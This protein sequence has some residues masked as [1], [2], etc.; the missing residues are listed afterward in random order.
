MCD[1]NITPQGVESKYLKQNSLLLLQTAIKGMLSEQAYVDL[2]LG[3]TMNEQIFAAA[4][5]VIHDIE[6]YVEGAV[7]SAA[8]PF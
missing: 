2:L 4:Y 8:K 1:F 5:G 3:G 7:L 6:E